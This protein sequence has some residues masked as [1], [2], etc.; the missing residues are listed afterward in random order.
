MNPF[1]FKTKKRTEEIKKREESLN[2]DIKR[3]AELARGCLNIKEFQGYK[4]EYQSLEAKVI[5][6]LLEYTSQWQRDNSADLSKYAMR[7]MILLTKLN[8][9]RIIISGVE[10]DAKRISE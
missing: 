10:S 2:S 1:D 6:E 3:I 8:S 7:V 9:L 4:I 5:N